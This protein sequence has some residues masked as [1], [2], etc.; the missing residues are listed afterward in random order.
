MIEQQKEQCRVLLY[1]F[2]NDVEGAYNR[3]SSVLNEVDRKVRRTHD[4]VSLKYAG[5]GRLLHTIGILEDIEGLFTDLNIE[6]D[7]TTLN[8]RGVPEDIS[9]AKL[10]IHETNNEIVSGMFEHGFSSAL[11]DFLNQNQRQND[12]VHSIKEELNKAGVTAEIEITYDE[13]LMFVPSGKQCQAVQDTIIDLVKEEEIVL[14]KESLTLLKKQ[15]WDD[16]NE[17][18]TE[19]YEKTADVTLS[20]GDKVHI[21]GLSKIVDTAKEQIE[22]FLE[23]NTIKTDVLFIDSLSIKFI[24]RYSTEEVSGIQRNLSEHHVTIKIRGKIVVWP[25][26]LKRFID[27]Q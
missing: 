3:L 16:L 26:C 17:D 25:P 2:T 11:V 7:G 22:R 10:K 15:I 9:E 4:T 18:L 14:E 8:L 1:G 5:R 6:F 19:R 27:V 23:E 24:K 12:V 20:E 13:C 21:I